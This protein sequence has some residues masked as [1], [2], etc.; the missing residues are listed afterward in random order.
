MSLIRNY[1]RYTGKHNFIVNYFFFDEKSKLKPLFITIIL[2]Y[3]TPFLIQKYLVEFETAI[4]L[5]QKR[6]KILVKNL[7]YNLEPK[8]IS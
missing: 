7:V 1:S 8:G 2:L 4:I 3:T 6:L 5:S